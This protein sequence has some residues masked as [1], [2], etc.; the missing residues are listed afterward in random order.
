MRRTRISAFALSLLF[1][2][3]F[4]GPV[5]AQVTVQMQNGQI[6]INNA[7]YDTQ[8][9]FRSIS[10]SGSG[11][12]WMVEDNTGNV[13]QAGDGSIPPIIIGD[14]Q[15]DD[16][17]D[18]PPP[19]CQECGYEDTKDHLI[20]VHGAV[21]QH[22]STLGVDLIWLPSAMDPIQEFFD[23]ITTDSL[24]GKLLIEHLGMAEITNFGNFDDPQYESSSS[25]TPYSF[26]ND[27]YYDDQWNLET[28]ILSK[29]VWHP[30][31]TAQKAVRVS[32]IDSG[33]AASQQGNDGLDGLAVT[34]TTVAPTSGSPV[35]HGLSI[36][37]LLA[38]KNDEGAG[39]GGLLGAWDS[40]GCYGRS[41]MLDGMEPQI[42]S[43]NAGDY[44]PSSIH[45]ARAI[46][47]SMTDGADVINLSLRMAYSPLVERAVKDALAAGITVVAAAGNYDPASPNKAATFPANIDGVI[48]V[49]A[50]DVN[51]QYIGT[52]ADQNVDIIAPGKDILVVKSDGNWHE[53]SGTSF[54]APHVTATVA[55]M[56]A[57]DPSLTPA[58]IAHAL[59]TGANH[60]GGTG[61][62][63][64][65][66]AGK[67]L[68]KIVSGGQQVV[69]HHEPFPHE[70]C[71][72]SKGGSVVASTMTEELPETPALTG[73]YPNP[74]NPETTISFQLPVNQQ[75][76]LA[77]YNTL[78]QR[79]QVLVDGWMESGRHEAHFRAEGLPTGTYFTRLETEAGVF[80]KSMVLMK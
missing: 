60:S 39:I 20:I 42:F 25:G 78:G 31:V 62:V 51:L 48:A 22:D 64:F 24:Y 57:I 4:A 54:A 17:P 43:Y 66:D 3:S 11:S 19:P 14:Y 58:N 41:S 50:G 35:D 10:K 40:D 29:V 69:W 72:A 59:K 52:S 73:N 71:G 34:H 65:L 5:L 46:R 53:V 80:T 1:L 44:A 70:V 9:A 77:V 32:I 33:V 36:V 18:P 26:P 75:V 55:L 38:D 7:G 2:A 56:R 67:T 16:P 8:E 47:Q 76:R 49:A 28:T 21:I 45:V 68:N 61:P 23:I 37:S 27:P 63:G 30:N 13:Y 12:D 79:V 15:D 6:I 74:F